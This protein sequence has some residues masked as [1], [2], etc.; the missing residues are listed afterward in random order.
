MLCEASSADLRG[1]ASSRGT[2]GRLW[3]DS[4]NESVCK[5]A[6]FTAGAAARTPER[7]MLLWGGQEVIPA[8]RRMFVN[9]VT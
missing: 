3:L 8:G 7:N 4:V 9:G 6:A 1:A 5:V 2:R